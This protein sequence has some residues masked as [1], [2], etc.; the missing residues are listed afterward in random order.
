M[1][2]PEIQILRSQVALQEALDAAHENAV[3]LTG[4]PGRIKD[5]KAEPFLTPDQALPVLVAELA[6]AQAALRR[7]HQELGHAFGE[8]LE[9]VEASE[10]NAEQ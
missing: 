6:S 10:A 7:Q 2:S 3:K 1:T 9:R 8:L 5:L 4:A